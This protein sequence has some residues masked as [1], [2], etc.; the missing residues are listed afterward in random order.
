MPDLD[1]FTELM[2][3]S[4]ERMAAEAG[5][6]LTAKPAAVA[7]PAKQAD[8]PAVPRANGNGPVVAN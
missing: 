3:G 4:L 5:V 7:R 1:R 6:S 2:R 8:A